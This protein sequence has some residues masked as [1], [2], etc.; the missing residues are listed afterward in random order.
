MTCTVLNTPTVS[1]MKTIPFANGALSTELNWCPTRE[2]SIASNVNAY[3]E[4]KTKTLVSHSDIGLVI[5]TIS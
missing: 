5:L 2:N 1:V 3:F 4:K